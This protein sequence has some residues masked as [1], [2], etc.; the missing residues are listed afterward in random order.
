MKTILET[1]HKKLNLQRYPINKNQTLQA[2]NAADEYL[3]QTV[4]E[5]PKTPQTKILVLNDSFGALTCALSDEHLIF[6]N[7]SLLSQKGLEQNLTANNIP[8]DKIQIIDSIQD[9]PS[10]IN[11]VILK[12]PKT[13]AMLEYQLIKIANEVAPGTVIIAASM[14]KELHTSTLKI[15]EKIIGKT[16]TS[17][18]K[19]KARLV[20]CEVPEASPMNK[21]PFPK[22]WELELP[23]KLLTIS[24]HAN[25]FSAKGLDL[26]ARFML[27]NFPAGNFENIIDLGCG[28]GVLGLAAKANY[29]NA[30]ITFTDESFMAIDSTKL[31]WGNNFPNSMNQAEFLLTDCL[32]GI[33]HNSAN[34]ILCNPPFHQQQI[35][36]D[37]IAM[38]MFAES[39]K[40]LTDD[41]QLMVIGNRH[42]GYHVKLKKYFNVV[43]KIAANSKFVIFLASNNNQVN[44]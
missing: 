43:N 27:E 24:N 7:D 25:I 31:N 16:T 14:V 40:V 34:L 17:L 32:Q 6:S 26:G 35:I 38:Q 1:E 37:E 29:N 21:Q 39:A 2:W 42:L 20:Y 10:E 36:T 8:K 19:K 30:K 3:I 12:I 9:L 4:I 44:S 28:N 5:Y 22:S 13:V 33:P 11:L 18:A 15:F 41:G 23:Q